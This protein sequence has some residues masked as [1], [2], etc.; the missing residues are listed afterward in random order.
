MNGH[1]YLDQFEP[2]TPRV[3]GLG[4]V[5]RIWAQREV[6]WDTSPL[7]Q[8]TEILGGTYQEGNEMIFPERSL[9]GIMLSKI[10]QTE[11]NT[12]CTISLTCGIV[13]KQTE[14]IEAE[15]RRDGG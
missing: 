6:S 15:N 2:R 9:E 1:G 14:L 10:S 4:C 13:K 5:V 12:Y 3:S 7:R 8:V 11:R